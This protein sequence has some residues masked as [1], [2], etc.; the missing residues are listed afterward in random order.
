LDRVNYAAA[1]SGITVQLGVTGRQYTGGSGED[2]FVSIEALLGSSFADHFVGTSAAETLSGGAGDDVLDGATGNNVIDGGAGTDHAIFDFSDRSGPI[3]LINGAVD[4]VVY[5][6]TAGGVAA[7]SVT[8][9]EVISITGGSGDDRIGGRYVTTAITATLNGNG[10]AD[11]A[12]A[13]LSGVGEA[14][15]GGLNYGFLFTD[16]R[17]SF[18]TLTSIEALVY[19]G[20]AYGSYG[21]VT[22]GARADTLT[23][24]NGNDIFYGSGGDD[25]LT[26]AGGDD[27]LDG[28]TGNN[29][30]DGGT[31]TDHAIFDFSERSSAVVLVNGA[32]DGVVYQATVG[33]VAAGSVTNVE[34]ISITGG[35]G[36][37]RIG[38]RY[39]TT[40]ITATLNGN[41]GADTAV[42]DLSGVGEAISG[43]LN[44]GF[45][46]TDQR[47]SFLTLTSIE[48]LVYTGNA[49]GSYGGVTGGARAD[50]LTGLNGNDIFYGSGGDDTLT[51]AG[52]DDVLDGGTGNNVI[53][54]GTGTDHAIF[55]F[56]ER[57]S[58]V[59]LVNGAVDGVVY[60]ATVGGVAAGS[61]T[62]V[63]AISIA[64][65]TGDDRIGARYVT[66][67]ITTR[68]NGGG[69]NDTV[70]ADLSGIGESISGGLNYGFLFTDQRGQFVTLTSIEALVY[71][72]NAFGSYGGITGGERADTLTGLGGNDVF[73]GNGGDDIL[74]G[75][76][77]DDLLDGG[78]G[79]D[80]IDGGTGVDHALFNF[81]DRTQAVL[82]VNA[83][84]AGETYQATVGGLAAGSVTGVEATSITGGTGDDR[85]GGRYAT[86]AITTTLNGGGG[87]D[88]AVIDLSG[89]TEAISGGTNYGFLYSDARGSFLNLTSIEAL[90]YTGNA[91]GGYGGITGGIGNDRLTGL[92]GNDVFD[93][94]RGDN[95]VDGG[96][97]IDQV[98]FDFSDRTQ[99]L[100]FVNGAQAGVTYQA[101]VGGV[102]AGSVVNVEAM[103]ITGGTGDDRIGGRFTA[104]VRSAL[105]GDAGLDTAVV[106]MTGTVG[107][108]SGGLPQGFLYSDS[109]GQF[110]NLL[111]VERLDYTG[112]AF[113]GYGGI[114]G[115]AG[116]DRLT[117]L[118]GNDYFDAG[119]G[120]NVVDG[121]DGID[122]AVFDFS[123]RT[124]A[125]VFVNGGQ[126]GVVYQATVGGVA[127][128]S[129]TNLEAL[130][131]SG[132]S[133]DDR[134]GGRYITTV[135]ATTLSGNAGTDTGVVDV[136]GIAEAISGG[137]DQGFLY[138]DIAG[139]FLN[140][141]G[142]ESLEYIG[143][144]FGGYGGITGGTG[145]DRLTG[146]GG[147]DTFRGGGGDDA[148][149]GG[150]GQNQ[151]FGDA[152]NDRFTS[153]GT[154]TIDGGEGEDRVFFAG[155][156]GDYDVMVEGATTSVVHRSSGL[157]ATLT[158][159]ER[160]SF[161]DQTIGNRA[162]VAPD[163]SG[164]SVAEDGTL[165]VSAA[166]LLARA[167]DADGDPLTITDVD[168][169]SH[170]SVGI[171]ADGSVRFLPATDFSGTAE[172]RFT[173]SDGAGG[174]ATARA[175]I[176]VTPVNDAPVARGDGPLTVH[177]GASLTVSPATLLANDSDAEGDSLA[178]LLAAG[179]AHGSL[180]TLADG[181]LVYTPAT[182]FAGSDSFTYQVS[183]SVL[184]S[185]VVAVVLEVHND[186]P[187]LAAGDPSA[188]LVEAGLGVAGT[189]A[190]TIDL[191]RA[192][193]D[194]PVPAYVLDGW[195]DLGGGRYRL[196]G[197]YGDVVLD[198][199]ADRLSYALDNGRAATEALL[200]GQQARDTFTLRVSDGIAQ[201]SK[202]VAFDI[203][204][205][206]DARDVHATLSGL[207]TTPEGAAYALTVSPL[208]VPAG[209]AI[210][211]LTVDWGDGTTSVLES[212]DVALAN[213]FT[214]TYADNAP[215]RAITV[216]ALANGELVTLGQKAVTIAN[217][218]P[219]IDVSGAATVTQGAPYTLALGA[220]VD[221]GSDTAQ[222][223]V[224]DW[225]NGTTTR[226]DRA[227]SA[228]FFP[229]SVTNSYANTGRYT[230]SVGIVDED[231]MFG[232][233]DTLSLF[234]ARDRANTAPVLKDD[235]FTVLSSD[236]RTG[237]VFLDNGA[238]RDLDPE[239]DAFTVLAVDGSEAAVGVA[240]RLA[241]GAL[242]T[243]NADG[244]FHYDPD[245]RFSPAPGAGAQ[246]SFTYT[247]IDAL[248]ATAT[249]TAHVTIRP[250][251][252]GPDLIARDIAF[253]GGDAGT[254]ATIHYTLANAGGDAV[255]VPVVERVYLSRDQYLSSDDLLVR[256]FFS[257]PALDGGESIERTFSSRLPQMLGDYYVLVAVDATNLVAERDETNLFAGAAP[258]TV[259][260][261]YTARVSASTAQAVAGQA[262]TL[263]GSAY[264]A[265]GITKMPFAV[266]QI[267]AIGG[268]TSREAY[269]L[270]D[271]QGNFALPFALA[272]GEAGTFSFTARYPQA[273]DEDAAPEAQVSFYGIDLVAQGAVPSF[274]AGGS[275][276]LAL[277]IRNP[278]D[279]DLTGLSVRLQGLGAG[280]TGVAELAAT[281]LAAH[282]ETIVTIDLS[283]T[284]A[285]AGG[286]DGFRVIVES[287]EGAVDAVDAGVRIVV[288]RA[289]LSF[290]TTELQEAMV[291]G[292][293]ETITVTLTNTGGATSGPLTVSLPPAPFL[294]LASVA[295]IGALA[296]GEST[297]ITLVLN[298]A[299]DLPL[300]V[301]NGAFTVSDPSG[302]AASLPFTF[303]AISDAVAGL[304]INLQDELTF[305]A[306]GAPLVENA[307][308]TVVNAVTNET[309]FESDDVDGTLHFDALP[310]GFYRI[311]INAPD[312]DRFGATIEVKAGE[313]RAVD[314][315][316]SLQ[317]VRTSWVV[318]QIGIEDGYHISV[319][320]DFITNVP[321]PVVVVTP[322]DVD[323]ADLDEVGE[324]KTV[325]FTA[326]N[327][328][329][330]AAHDFL[331]TFQ[332]HPLYRIDVPFDSIPTIDADSAVS[333]EVTFTRIRAEAGDTVEG[334]PAAR[335]MAATE[336][337]DLLDCFIG[338]IAEYGFECGNNFIKKQ[339]QIIINGVDC[340]TPGGDHGGDL[341]G[342]FAFYA[343]FTAF[344]NAWAQA[345]APII[346]AV[347]DILP[348]LP[349][350]T[351]ASYYSVAQVVPE[352]EGCYNL[353]NLLPCFPFLE[354][355]APLLEPYRTPPPPSDDPAGDFIKEVVEYY[356]RKAFPPLDGLMTIIE[357]VQG[358]GDFLGVP[359]YEIDYVGPPA[360]ASARGSD[361]GTLHHGGGPIGSISDDPD[362]AL[363]QAIEGART[364]DQYLYEFLGEAT[365]RAL[366]ADPAA[367]AAFVSD[368]LAMGGLTPTG[369]IPPEDLAILIQRYGGSLPLDVIQGFVGRLNRTLEYA[370]QGIDSIDDV[371]V[372]ESLD[373]IATDRL[374]LAAENL[375]ELDEAAQDQGLADIRDLMEAL[376]DIAEA[377]YAMQS[378]G[379]CAEITMQIDQEAVLTRQ[380]F[381]GTL[382]IENMLPADLTDIRFDL[383]LRD[384]NGQV[385]PA[386][387]FA[388]LPPE[389]DGITAI[390]GTGIIRGD[391]D[392]VVTFT[393]I[394]TRDA[395]ADVNSIYT[396]GGTLSY[397]AGETILNIP[398]SST[399]I[400][401]VPQPELEL[402]YFF[403]R[404]V[405]GDDPFTSAVEPSEPFALGLIVSNV[406]SGTA[407]S[408]EIESG[409]PR[410][411]ENEKGL[412]VDFD[413]IGT[414][415]NGAGFTPSLKVNFGDVAPGTSETATFLLTSSLQG[416]F[417]DYEA[418]FRH[419]NAIGGLNLSLITATRVHELIH[420]GDVNRDG[421][422]DFLTNEVPDFADRPDTLFLADGS[423][424][425]VAAA[426]GSIVGETHSGNLVT[427]TISASDPGD[428]W[429]YL[430]LIVPA[431]AGAIVSVL[432]AD[433]S[434]VEAGRYWFTDRSFYNNSSN[435]T[436][437]D[438]IH[439]LD[440]QAAGSYTMVFQT[441]FFLLTQG[442]TDIVSGGAASDAFV[443][444][445]TLDAADRVDGGAG[446]D[447][448]IGLQGN[449]AG[450]T[451]DAK[452]L[453]DIET[454]ALL[455][456]TDARFG[457][458]AGN[459]YSY[460]LR[461]VDA[462]VA[463]SRQLIVNANTLKA[464]ETLSFDGSAESTGSFRI[465]AGA[466][467][468]ILTGGNG[469]DQIYG[470]LGQ[471]RMTGNGGNDT[472]YFRS[473]ADSPTT[474]M[475]SILDFTAGDRIDLSMIDADSTTD[476]D[477]AFAFIGSS[478]FTG[479]PG[480][481]RVSGSGTS[482]T[483]EIDVDGDGEADMAVA[484]TTTV[485]DYGFTALDFLP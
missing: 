238:G 170:G 380:A 357:C 239:G 218:A 232:G 226:L 411:V 16:Q 329:L 42:A 458:T 153:T 480:E 452:N 365:W 418:S 179:P 195:T 350:S 38:A 454:L 9:V 67:A 391:S 61:V 355:I 261:A 206:A 6:A 317:T 149:A 180:A 396:V 34:V 52:G 114:S 137:I 310:E 312:H 476:G 271:A 15:S 173:V 412:L 176:A 435:A 279:L 45:L 272:Q 101:T 36:D 105:N 337:A 208:T 455:S 99:A 354:P 49:Y 213:G 235:A 453:V 484:V 283:S 147:N 40:A 319:E 424:A 336:G 227:A 377:P 448:Q 143:N 47:G 255:P 389:L 58:A 291:R 251:S 437:E 478:V 8:N 287:A 142:L 69:G 79:N 242:L 167:T 366:H 108:I 240:T 182:G 160:L 122:H 103:I 3:L 136:S 234:V 151:L 215:T 44:Y 386:D 376:T 62:N 395:A 2:L 361:M 172:F 393:I 372:G 25:T 356:M 436:Y 187:T 387:I 219:D 100:V 432:R 86:T 48:A 447:D 359:R 91:Y 441:N 294:S 259:A 402:D 439:I 204:G 248:G 158:S 194:G 7:G 207:A 300:A 420:A 181:S 433:G 367:T 485:P 352:F 293:A 315:F 140:L 302:A 260:S 201:T 327:H 4:G 189:T 457:D 252:S 341:G 115:G 401:V 125:V 306:E 178:F 230:I 288:P 443:F 41:G 431:E 406:G 258:G 221:P 23:G 257:S 59:V 358:I 338:A 233:V 451:F 423:R 332:D 84:L 305:F 145:G 163:V 97:G 425:D 308:V 152:G 419:R 275:G 135:I 65:G 331:L 267:V 78:T 381:E 410:I 290:D 83:G 110:L 344:T 133:G 326:T 53:D 157:R 27:V 51:G 343:G 154:D 127:A 37:D 93:A 21:G 116:D 434:A 156:L 459:L 22:G 138:S 88:T 330:I 479:M 392:G 13:D 307:V 96:G 347:P 217:V 196:A 71:T 5:Q 421:I 318:K 375:L 123:D 385:V 223:I 265:D 98:A 32:V 92:A 269:A 446:A 289:E 399:P 205:T 482:W 404:N 231:G 286:L 43:G 148:I 254:S 334:S 192:D 340:G 132:G 212:P 264:L 282:G 35:S 295:T 477:D 456:G 247:V 463:G 470:R 304:T 281:S 90:V 313:D 66:T 444:G 102:A 177:A 409:Q 31:G 19:T 417:E 449:Y 362:V 121:G 107:G 150:E 382:Q 224:I 324:S 407:R 333:F 299:A 60:Q 113:G 169:P 364:I 450:Y 129:A 256:E 246:D 193:P 297:E 427:L 400:V 345:F 276:E 243:L 184:L 298:P 428:G 33:G 309:V 462:N 384:A 397:R 467:D 57:S 274:V 190:A 374:L 388:I 131:I 465:V 296:P 175:T 199:G 262:I 165:I 120:D 214:R 1:T 10:G 253:D 348:N 222:A 413:I 139:R 325:T 130:H 203:A 112:N 87:S 29:V 472:F 422:S 185:Q 373:F 118:G 277:T 12:V 464:G 346:E 483:V 229:D 322:G 26:G 220:I 188:T 198:V 314:A 320:A 394:P 191:V 128:G 111:N 109:A 225:G 11:T 378:G 80:V 30:I 210:T 14:I 237:S 50:T 379:V 95:V 168:Q 166:T 209:V 430:D 481:V 475:D 285:A 77:G 371:P 197:A 303:K 162:P 155:N 323:I 20:N 64:G 335:G 368:T 270:T 353:F 146:L 370:A 141:Q 106:D 186:A 18:L 200:Q 74:T 28:G 321:V 70:V 73:Y 460:D 54:G 316:M 469:A 63:E 415:V 438:R 245:G 76:G 46:F 89:V 244:T 174:T 241:S 164:L 405:F 266:V 349:G 471:D 171:L 273:V 442:G 360:S 94:G 134:I 311:E 328:G 161:A 159:V 119:R 216:T 75:G 426:S 301:Y 72:G 468:D 445:A 268:G 202:A 236:V 124:L 414:T 117:G 429:R 461:M 278:G 369:T 403:Q 292:D 249:A 466:G 82:L 390:D 17:G 280:V 68:L 39:V 24:L 263:S 398:V 342:F 474:A 85:I 416:H 144:A 104:L 56:S 126:S 408:L 339:S 211:R 363:E 228:P 55:D 250:Q 81:S 383:V 284:T 351:P 440:D 473:L 183:D